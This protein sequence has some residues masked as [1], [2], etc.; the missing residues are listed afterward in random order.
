MNEWPNSLDASQQTVAKPLH[1]Y[2]KK[3]VRGLGQLFKTTRSGPQKNSL[4]VLLGDPAIYFTCALDRV[5]SEKHP[6]NEELGSQT[7]LG[8]KYWKTVKILIL[9]Q[10]NLDKRTNLKGKP[11][12]STS[13]DAP[14][15]Q[16]ETRQGQLKIQDYESPTAGSFGS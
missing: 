7:N 15:H 8:A 10:R 5:P 13:L 4:A 1:S 2:I 12:K 11:S 16:S 3:K 6:W 14:T 9:L